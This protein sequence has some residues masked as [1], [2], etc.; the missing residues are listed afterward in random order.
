MRILVC[1]GTDCD[2]RDE[3][4]QALDAVHRKHGVT[5]IINGG[6][7]GPDTYGKEWADLNCIPCATMEANWPNL[8]RKAGPIRN[9]AMLNLLF[10]DAVV[11]M[12]G[13]RGTEGMVKLAEDDGVNVWRP[14]AGDSR[15]TQS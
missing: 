14:L 6:A 2:K 5:L 15:T 7:P 9:E 1:G 13:N 3:T 4:F 12:P 10:P 11:A 8:G